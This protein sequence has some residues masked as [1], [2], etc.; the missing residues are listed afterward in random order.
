MEGLEQLLPELKVRT[1]TLQRAML[2]VT[3]VVSGVAFFVN[4]GMV[5]LSDL[6]MATSLLLLLFA[7]FMG[8]RASK[9]SGPHTMPPGSLR[10]G[11]QPEGQATLVFSSFHALFLLHAVFYS[12]PLSFLPC[13]AP[14]LPSSIFL[15]SSSYLP[16]WLP[17]F[18]SSLPCCL[19]SLPYL[20][21]TILSGVV[22]VGGCVS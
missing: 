9:V 15:L 14:F 7:A 4:V 11:V 2:N 17:S 5:V 16:F 12:F 10:L 21:N 1:P 13:L 6:K 19:P 22:C 20:L 3:L 8:L 18:H